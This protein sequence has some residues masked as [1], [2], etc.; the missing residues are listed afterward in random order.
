[1]PP[2]QSNQPPAGYIPPAPPMPGHTSHRGPGYIPTPP[3]APKRSISTGR[4]AGSGATRLQTVS[5]PPNLNCLT[6][7]LEFILQLQYFWNKKMDPSK[8][9]TTS[10]RHIFCQPAFCRL[11]PMGP[12]LAQPHL[13]TGSWIHPYAASGSQTVDFN[14]QASP[15]KGNVAV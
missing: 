11:H 3:P 14:R 15:V 10:F 2:Q 12:I 13:P 9:Q 6:K 1:M 8:D 5:L 7:T 4:L